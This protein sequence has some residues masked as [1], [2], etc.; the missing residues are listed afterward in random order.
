MRASGQSAGIGGAGRVLVKNPIRKY[1]FTP[2]PTQVPPEVLLEMARPIIHHRTP[3][4]SAVLDQA[5]ERMKP[6]LGTR[7]EVL[8]LASS[9]TGAME[10]TVTNLLAPG[11]HALYVNG[12]KFGE[13][14]GK[15]LAAN[16][17]GGHPITAEWGRLG[18]P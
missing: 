15:L 7:E 2:G 14:W 5:R 1:L 9:G 4:F 11:D 18:R 8:V 6:L 3:E 10:A 13:R 12:G 16:G 17:M